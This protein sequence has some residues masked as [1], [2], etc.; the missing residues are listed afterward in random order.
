[1][2]NDWLVDALNAQAFTALNAS[3]GVRAFYDQQRAKGT[4]HRR[5]GAG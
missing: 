5:A 2:H 3:P 4:E 1:M